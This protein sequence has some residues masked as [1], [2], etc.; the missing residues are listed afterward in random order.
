MSVASAVKRL[1]FQ[2]SKYQG[3]IIWL[4]GLAVPKAPDPIEATQSIPDYHRFALNDQNFTKE[5][6]EQLRMVAMVQSESQA[7]VNYITR[8]IDKPVPTKH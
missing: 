8:C 2:R 4:V 7:L 5:E 6:L 1:V 3:K